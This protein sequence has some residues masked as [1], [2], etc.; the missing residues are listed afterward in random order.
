MKLTEW[1]GTAWPVALAASGQNSTRDIDDISMGTGEP[2]TIRERIDSWMNSTEPSEFAPIRLREEKE[3]GWLGHRA[4]AVMSYLPRSPYTVVLAAWALS[5]ALMQS[6]QHLDNV[7]WLLRINTEDPVEADEALG[8]VA[9][10][11]ERH[12]HSK[13]GRASC[14]ERV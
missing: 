13:I 8:V 7:A 12:S 5:R 6:P 9:G 10:R 4:V 3:W 2:T 11:L 14:R 1:L